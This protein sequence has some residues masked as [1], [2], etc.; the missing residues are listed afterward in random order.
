MDL[1]RIVAP[2]QRL[3]D[4]DV[5]GAAGHRRR[6]GNMLFSRL[7]VRHVFRHPLAWP[8][9]DGV[10]SMQ[11]VAIEATLDTS[12][13]FLRV[14]TTHLEFEIVRARSHHGN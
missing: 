1:D 14:T 12:P 7:P 3:A 8:A 11:R 6:L 4:F 5:L 2:A 9:V 10:V 13:G